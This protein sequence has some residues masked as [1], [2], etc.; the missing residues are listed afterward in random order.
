MKLL[1]WLNEWTAGFRLRP[2]PRRSR[3][4]SDSR[5]RRLQCSARFGQPAETLEARTLLTTF[6]VDTL[7]DATDAIPGDGSADDGSGNVTLRAAIQEANALAGDDDIILPAGVVQLSISGALEDAAAT[8][9]LDILSNVTI[10]GAGAGVTFIDFNDLDRLFDIFSGATVTIRDVTL[11]DGDVALFNQNGGGIRNAG[12]LTVEDSEFSSLSAL[13]GG[14]LSNSSSGNTTIR[15]SLFTGNAANGGSGGGA[16]INSGTLL[17]EESTFDSNGAVFNG[18]AIANLGPTADLTLIDSTVSG[19][20][21]PTGIQDGGGLYNLSG[22]VEIISSTFSANRARNGAGLWTGGGSSMV[23]M[24]YSTFSGNLA[25]FGRGGGLFAHMNGDLVQSYFST[26][27]NNTAGDGGGAYMEGG[28]LV[29]E[30]TILAEN[31]GLNSGDESIGSLSSL[32]YNL[33]G[34]SL[35]P[36]MPSDIVTTNPL[37]GPL[38]DNGGPTM[39]HALLPGSPAIDTADPLATEMVDQRGLP[40][41]QDFDGDGTPEHDIGAFEV[42]PVTLSG[43]MATELRLIRNGGDLELRDDSDNSLIQSTPYYDGGSVTIN[44]SGNDDTLTIDFSAG[45]VVPLSDVTFNAG[46]QSSGGDTLAL[47]SGSYETITHSFA[48]AND[49]SITL[50]DGSDPRTVNYTGLE[51]ISDN[52]AATD[53]VF[54][55]G[56]T[57]DD[58]TLSDG[59]ATSDGVTRIESVSSSETVDFATPTSS[60]TINTA[61][62]DDNVTLTDVDSTFAGIVSVN[63]DGGAD[64]VDAS[65]F[66]QG[67]TVTGGTGNDSLTGSAFADNLTGN[68]DNDMIAAGDGNDI[69]NGGSG[70]DELLGEDGDDLVQ[71]QGGTGD[72]LDGGDGNDTL[73]GGSGNDLIRETF[74]GD[75]TLTNSTMT[76]RGSDTVISAERA[77]LFGGG[78]AQ[79]IDVSTFFTAGLTSVTLNGAGGDDILLGSAGNDVLVGSG[80]SDRV[81]GN[82]GHDRLIGGSGGDTLIGGDGNDLLRGL[83]GSGDRLSGGVGDDTINGGRGVDRVFETGDVDFTLTN[84]SMTGLGTDVVLAMEIAE[85]NGGASANTIDASAFLGFKGFTQLRGNGGNDT[86]IGTDGVDIITGGDGDD[87]LVGNDGNDVLNGDAGN[88]VLQGKAGNDTLNGGDGNDGL[89]GFTGDDVLNGERGYDRGYGGEGNDTLTGGNAR[90]TLIGGNGDDALDGNAADDT[91]VGGTGNNDASLGDVFTDATATIDETFMLDP[92]PAWVDQV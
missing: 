22:T 58:V 69:L 62:G 87:S 27:T 71:G 68:G 1:P 64:S 5:H 46:G 41:P 82:S 2:Q 44:G 72:T 78:A 11:L 32:G 18:G 92:L 25:T 9:D 21:V 24:T 51:P 66:S 73:S 77:F 39:T 31:T 59:A 30:N 35:T 10:T 6:T 34:G 3:Q 19:N 84:S 23:T 8:G 50:D 67:V 42:N 61:D 54:D 63:T 85:L 57:S 20:A 40:R 90:D 38:A 70:K 37:L 47:E 4:T 81:V 16:V 55:F 48:N 28:G 12:T 60:L 79:T 43:G 75:A 52:L 29:I 13:G 14:A 53:R 74:T 76:G 65:A 80:G 83:G 15:R 86:I 36:G 17:I 33:L 26:I 91:L 88:D 89:T 49:G 45:N 7:T 56:A